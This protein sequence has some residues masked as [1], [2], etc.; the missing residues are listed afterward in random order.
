MKVTK[1]YLS[2]LIQELEEKIDILFATSG[3]QAELIKT[4]QKRNS[5]LESNNNKTLEQIKDYVKELEQ[6]RNYYVSSNDNSK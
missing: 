3:K 4:L 2:G 5:D 6:I 1:Q